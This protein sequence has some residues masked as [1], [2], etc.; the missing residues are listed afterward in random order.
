MEVF[1]RHRH[2]FAPSYVPPGRDAAVAFSNIDLRF[3]NPH[4]FPVRIEGNIRNGRLTVRF[5]GPG[6][7]AQTPRVASEVQDVRRPATFELGGRDGRMR[8]RNTG[9]P[10]CDVAVYRHWPDGRRELISHDTYP[11]MARVVQRP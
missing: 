7:M 11:V 2:R 10:G 3:R 8:V 5:V 1:E 6:Q 9:K 4:P